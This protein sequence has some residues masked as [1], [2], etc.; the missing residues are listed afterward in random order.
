MV[1]C[2]DLETSLGEI[3]MHVKKWLCVEEA[4]K[5]PI[6][7]PWGLD[8]LPLAFIDLAFKSLM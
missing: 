8:L 5:Q 6:P 2:A 7:R 3:L 1:F 4:L